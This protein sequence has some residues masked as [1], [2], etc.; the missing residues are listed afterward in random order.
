M[1][2]CLR[3]SASLSRASTG[4]HRLAY[5]SDGR[6]AATTT[7]KD[8]LTLK[9]WAR[10]V[11]GQD[12]HRKEPLAGN[13]AEYAASEYESALEMSAATSQSTPGTPHSYSIPFV[14][15]LRYSISLQHGRQFY[16]LADFGYIVLTPQTTDALAQN[17][18]ELVRSSQSFTILLAK[19]IWSGN[20]LE[21]KC[22]SSTTLKLIVR[23]YDPEEGQALLNQRDIHTL[24]LKDLPQAIFVHF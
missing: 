4:S 13:L 20:A 10:V 12:V 6:K 8:Y 15:P 5:S 24:E 16:L 21:F 1:D 18:F 7:S 3:G 9:G 11:V 2:G 14:N 19:A 17:F 22:K 23:L